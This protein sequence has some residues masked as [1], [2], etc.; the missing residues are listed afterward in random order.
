MLTC[1]LNHARSAWDTSLPRLTQRGVCFTRSLAGSKLLHFSFFSSRLL[2]SGLGRP[3]SQLHRLYRC[4]VSE[5]RKLSHVGSS[6]TKFKDVTQVKA[7]DWDCFR[8]RVT[9]SRHSQNHCVPRKS[10][11]QKN[12][13]HKPNLTSF[14]AR[15]ICFTPKFILHSWC[16]QCSALCVQMREKC[17]YRRAEVKPR[18]APKK[19]SAHSTE[20]YNSLLV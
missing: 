9:I 4:W 18:I 20:L 19:R 10:L 13:L 5:R 6:G 14:D 1:F 3:T 16:V 2:K 15:R 7:R 12:L 11:E 17:M 8:F